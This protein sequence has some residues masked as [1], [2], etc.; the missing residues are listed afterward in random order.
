MHHT[1]GVLEVFFFFRKIP[2]WI[3]A[4]NCTIMVAFFGVQTPI[5]LNTHMGKNSWLNARSQIKFSVHFN[6]LCLEY[7]F[8]PGIDSTLVL[9]PLPETLTKALWPALD[10]LVKPPRKN[11]LLKIE[12]SFTPTASVSSPYTYP[13]DIQWYNIQCHNPPYII[14]GPRN[15]HKLPLSWASHL[16]RA[17]WK[18]LTLW[19]PSQAKESWGVGWE[20]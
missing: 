16:S 6:C 17:G 19:I 5:N 1:L 9:L 3:P 15:A 18:L 12:N 13:M 20:G 14:V 11:F 2:Y 4:T 10:I 7:L 8:S